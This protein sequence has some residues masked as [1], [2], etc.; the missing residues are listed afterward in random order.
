MYTLY[1]N[2]FAQSL[3]MAVTKFILI[4]IYLN[5]SQFTSYLDSILRQ[6][7]L[8]SCVLC[9]YVNRKMNKFPCHISYVTLV[10]YRIPS[11]YACDT[12]TGRIKSLE[13]FHCVP[14]YNSI[15]LSM[16]VTEFTLICIYK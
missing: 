2:I 7:I 5:L 9:I 1:H 11:P 12:C 10:Y 16:A 4:Y 3:N 13:H 6:F 8:S 15:I 14:S